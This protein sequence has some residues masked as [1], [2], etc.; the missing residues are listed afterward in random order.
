MGGGAICS[1]A[2]VA[3]G[4]VITDNHKQDCE[5]VKIL[6]IDENPFFKDDELQDLDS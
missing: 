1:A 2:H 3:K 5:H 6:I 4:K